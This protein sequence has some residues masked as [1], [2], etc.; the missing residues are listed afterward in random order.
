MGLSQN[1]LKG[2]FIDDDNYEFAKDIFVNLIELDVSYNTIDN[3]RDLMICTNFVSIQMLDIT[4]NPLSLKPE[5][6]YQKLY[7]TLSKNIS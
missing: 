3:E 5:N 4:G 2:I 7:S 1:R 6:D